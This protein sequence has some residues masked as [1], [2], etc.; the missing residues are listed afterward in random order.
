MTASTASAEPVTP[1]SS[2]LAEPATTSVPDETSYEPV[3]GQNSA[4]LA[5]DQNPQREYELP[6]AETERQWHAF[7]APFR[8]ELAARGFVARLEEITGLD[9]RINKLEA[10]VY[11]VG[12]AYQSDSDKT[13]HLTQISDA[14]GLDLPQP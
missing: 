6:L 12:F 11:Q 10:G 3:A 14:T 7:W 2:P 9:Y 5:L 1:E 13:A 8:S 4:A